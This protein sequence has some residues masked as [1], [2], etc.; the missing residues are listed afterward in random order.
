MLF[1]PGINTTDEITELSS[2]KNS[3]IL[4]SSKLDINSGLSQSQTESEAYQTDQTP[5][6]VK[7]DVPCVLEST[8]DI[9]SFKPLAD[10]LSDF[11]DPPSKAAGRRRSAPSYRRKSLARKDSPSLTLS[12]C[13]SQG[14]S[15]QDVGI[16][17]LNEGDR[18]EEFKRKK[19]SE[20]T[21][22]YFNKN[23]ENHE[24]VNSEISK[25]INIKK[26]CAINIV[27]FEKKEE[28][29]YNSHGDKDNTWKSHGDKENTVIDTIKNEEFSQVD[30]FCST[31]IDVKRSYKSILSTSKKKT[32]TSTKRVRFIKDLI[33]EVDIDSNPGEIYSCTNLEPESL[34][35]SEH[36][37]K[38]E[39]SV[40]ENVSINVSPKENE[41]LNVKNN[42]CT[43]KQETSREIRDDLFSQVSPTVL[44]EM[45]SVGSD[46]N[47][48]SL[49]ISE[50][51]RISSLTSD[52]ASSD[53]NNNADD[54]IKL[55]ITIN[56]ET[57]V[58][59]PD[60]MKSETTTSNC[61]S[62]EEDKNL[63]LGRESLRKNGSS[64]LKKVGKVKRF[65]YPTNSQINTSCPK[66]VYGFKQH[67]DVAE[68]LD[69]NQT[70]IGTEMEGV[71]MTSK[72]ITSD[73]TGTK[74]GTPSSVVRNT[75]CTTES[76]EFILLLSFT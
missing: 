3:K 28:N 72:L 7:L 29:T 68:T 1:S 69:N 61:S 21:H 65:F 44:E 58:H 43:I 73:T 39:Q 49:Q 66:T 19:W 10:V 34:S 67:H 27:E 25:D 53:S 36:S 74:S 75:K 22:K 6:N 50:S 17:P 45:C 55:P 54:T 64:M 40:Q 2:V 14:D 47:E 38:E 52:N 48:K 57:L 9:E 18:Y 62:V 31:P 12:K 59:S 41:N 4:C 16:K 11:F 37:I 70:S 26:E 33:K 63:A 42:T 51:E 76:G 5:N 56:E 8:Q 23:C 60:I 35:V 15:C 71:A 46:Q 24:F 20:G 32:P 30:L 13:L